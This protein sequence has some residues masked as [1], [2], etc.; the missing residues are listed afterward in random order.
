MD[1]KIMKKNELSKET[2]VS[3]KEITEGE[4]EDDDV[5]DVGGGYNQPRIYKSGP[6]QSPLA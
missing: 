2:S 1:E 5:K 6:E 4:L 3:E